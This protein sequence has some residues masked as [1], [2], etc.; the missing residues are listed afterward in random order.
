MSRQEILFTPVDLGKLQVKNRVAMAPM[1]R[2]YS[3]G[4][5]PNSKN[6][7]YYKARA[8]GGVGLIITEGT[9]VGHK[10]A[11]A[12]PNVPAFSGD[13]SLAGWKKVVDAVHEA[14][15]KIAP[16]LWHVGGVRRP[17]VEPG[18]AEPGHS[19]SGM[20][21][22]GKVT[23]HA[24]E[25]ADIDE[26]I[27]AFAKAAADAKKIG[28]DAIELHGAHG[29]LIDQFFWDGTNVRED[30]YGGDLAGRS[31]FALELVKAVRAAVGEDF[32]IIFR[33]SQ[34]KQQD[35]SARLCETPEELEGFL[36]PLAE[37]GVDIFHCSTRR[38]WEPEFEGSDLNLAGWA[39]KLTGKPTITVGSVGLNQDFLPEDG[40]VEF[41]E[42]E[43]ASLDN[44]IERFEKDEFDMVAV[45]RAL[46]AN[47]DWANQ[48]QAG[49]FDDLAAYEKD[50]LQKLV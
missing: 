40:F 13:D 41:N 14:G 20:A 22:P 39:R 44:L 23:G 5:V 31:R 37:A 9:F 15:G 42:A 17:G 49:K 45:G 8:E 3:P 47:P 24:M 36:K 11:I 2:M 18:G 10:A 4:N 25:Q 32:P 38:F 26:V 12:Y 27:A 46:I 1:T 34:W 30:E 43:P 48:V 16:Q 29:Y 33:F 19:P 6:I 28:F 50:M 35:Y 7:A 21:K